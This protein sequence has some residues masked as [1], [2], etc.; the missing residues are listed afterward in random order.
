MLGNIDTDSKLRN[1]S[2]LFLVLLS[3]KID[4][5]VAPSVMC[6]NITLGTATSNL[7]TKTEGQIMSTVR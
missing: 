7:L 3:W 5:D 6:L 2:T 1:S 4:M